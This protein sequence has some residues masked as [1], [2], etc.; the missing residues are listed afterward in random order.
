M[1]KCFFPLCYRGLV[2]EFSLSDAPLGTLA[3]VTVG[4]KGAPGTEAKWHLQRVVVSG[5]GGKRTFQ[6][7]EW[8]GDSAGA[9]SQRVL[10][11]SRCE[12]TH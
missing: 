12:L 7:N 3:A 1:Q 6:C 10:V 5:R 11:A 4:L 9:P 8:L 2:A